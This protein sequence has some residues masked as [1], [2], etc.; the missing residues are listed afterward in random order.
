M[1]AHTGPQAQEAG[2]D[3]IRLIQGVM[4]WVSEGSQADLEK[5]I[6]IIRANNHALI[7][8]PIDTSETLLRVAL[9]KFN[10]RAHV[11]PSTGYP[12]FDRRDE[13]FYE[14]LHS[15]V[16]DVAALNLDFTPARNED[17]GHE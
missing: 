7:I 1:N 11:D 6:A 17:C 10:E 12:E 14:R 3:A 13:D 15:V 5:A 4:P 2:G 8:D 16:E 9:D